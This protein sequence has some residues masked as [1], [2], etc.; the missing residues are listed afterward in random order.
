MAIANSVVSKRIIDSETKVS[1]KIL[2]YS[3]KA[4]N[5]KD[6]AIL[7]REAVGNIRSLNDSLLGRKPAC[8][9]ALGINLREHGEKRGFKTEEEFRD[10]RDNYLQKLFTA[11]YP[12]DEVLGAAGD[13]GNGLIYSTVSGRATIIFER[14]NEGSWCVHGTARFYN[15]WIAESNLRKKGFTT[16]VFG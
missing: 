2:K 16:Q 1:I 15:P 8:A 6:A 3:A 10:F 11:S 14:D 7:F 5:F 12:N 13:A 4:E 9:E